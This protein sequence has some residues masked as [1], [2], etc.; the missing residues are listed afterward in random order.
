MGKKTKDTSDCCLQ[1]HL[2]KFSKYLLH[3]GPGYPAI[4]LG[5]SEA[6]HRTSFIPLILTPPGLGWEEDSLGSG[7][8]NYK[9]WIMIL[10]E[11]VKEF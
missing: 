1:I 10:R 11:R 3:V 5:L 6:Y 8:N 2:S 7:K 9:S 4:H